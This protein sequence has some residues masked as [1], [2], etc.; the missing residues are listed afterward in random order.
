MANETS[1]CKPVPVH[2][3]SVVATPSRPKS[4]AARILILIRFHPPATLGLIL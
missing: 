3:L 4:E 2:W 1:S